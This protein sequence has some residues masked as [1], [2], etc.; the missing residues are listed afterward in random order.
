MIPKP[1]S[2]NSGECPK[3]GCPDTRIA[4]QWNNWN[5]IHQLRKCDACSYAWVHNTKQIPKVQL[6][7]KSGGVRCPHCGA[8]SSKVRKTKD[9]L[10]F[11]I[12]GKCGKGFNSLP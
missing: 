4:D 11:H 9:D 5:H 1:P 3:C 7:K 8:E 12:C 10:R 2:D 6:Y